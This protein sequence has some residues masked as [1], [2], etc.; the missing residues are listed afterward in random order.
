MR[1]L[2][3]NHV[4]TLNARGSAVVGPVGNPYLIP[5]NTNPQQFNIVPTVGSRP[6]TTGR[7][8]RGR[9]TSHLMNQGLTSDQAEQRADAGLQA[10][11]NQGGESH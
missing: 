9:I 2:A 10:H 3:S 5:Y 4:A 7:L 1:L 11:L 8:N 6:G